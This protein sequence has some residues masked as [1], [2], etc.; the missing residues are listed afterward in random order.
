MW[1]IPADPLLPIMVRYGVLVCMIGM[2][3]LSPSLF[4]ASVSMLW[5]GYFRSAVVLCPGIFSVS[6]RSPNMMTIT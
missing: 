6:C 5:C 2:I 3:D 4:V 1:S